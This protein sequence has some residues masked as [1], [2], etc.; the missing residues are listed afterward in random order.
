PHHPFDPPAPWSGMYDPAALTILPGWTERMP[1]E[2]AALGKG[3][4]DNTTL[5]EA[6]LREVMAMYYATISQ[7]DHHVGRMIALLAHKGL[8]D[9]TLIVFTSDHGEYLGFHHRLL[10]GNHMYDPM[11]K[12]PLI[13]KPPGQRGAGTVS[14]A[15]VSNVDV[16][17]TILAAAGCRRGEHMRGLDLAARPGGRDVV[18][19]EDG[20]RTMVRTRTHKLLCDRDG[21]RS[22]LLDLR[23]DPLE[24]ENLLAQGE[25][26]AV[27]E[28]LRERLLRWALFD[29]PTPTHRWDNAPRIDQPNVPAP[30]DAHRK[31][32]IEYYRR[33]MAGAGETVFGTE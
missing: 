32:M 9:D 30:D 21:A 26:R 22:Q 28:D 16:A 12:V 24:M 15:L 20:L 4:F 11:V 18:F 2:D 13:I 31:R 5:T 25:H 7:I 19:A 8:Y 17:A 33:K 6:A 23:A 14:D 27:A 10:K 1:P 29:A 3:Y